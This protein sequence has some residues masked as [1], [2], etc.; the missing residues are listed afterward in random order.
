MTLR[1]HHLAVAEW[2]VDVVACT[3]EVRREPGLDGYGSVETVR[4]GTRIALAAFPDVTVAV[5]DVLP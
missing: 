1:R 5:S 3:I 2:L 4:R